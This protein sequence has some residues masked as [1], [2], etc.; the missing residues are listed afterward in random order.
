MRNNEQSQ[1]SVVSTR[2]HNRRR[3]PDYSF[4][5]LRRARLGSTRSV[6]PLPS[7]LPSRRTV[8]TRL[9][10][11]IRAAVRGLWILG[12]CQSQRQV[13]QPANLVVSGAALGLRW[14]P[15]HSPLVFDLVREPK[16]FPGRWAKDHTVGKPSA[17]YRYLANIIGES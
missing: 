7:D 12:R 14:L 15:R 2:V 17:G 6:R 4:G 5:N 3:R 1:T 13:C 9:L 11:L 10:Q 16:G 8:D